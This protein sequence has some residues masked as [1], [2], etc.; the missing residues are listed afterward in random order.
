MLSREKGFVMREQIKESIRGLLA[1]G[2]GTQCILG[3]AWMLLQF[4]YM[5]NLQRTDDYIRAAQGFVM[6][7]YMG[8]LYPV[9]IAGANIL[10]N[11]SGVPFYCFLYLLQVSIA[12]AAGS[13]FVRL[14][15][16]GGGRIFSLPD[17]AV[18]LFLLTVPM[19]MQCH[20]AVLPLS[21]VCSAFLVEL[22]LCYGAFAGK[23]K[24]DSKFFLLLCGLWMVMGL[25]QPDYLWLA[26]LPV[27]CTGVFC[28]FRQG[29]WKRILAFVA[30][31]AILLCD[32][33]RVTASPGSYGRIQ[34]TMG[35]AMVSRM[36]WPNFSTTYFFWPEEVKEVMSEHQGEDISA[37]ADRVQTVFGPMMEEAFGKD[38][39]DRY[40]WQ[41]ALQCFQVRTKE[42]VGTIWADFM[43]YLCVPL[44]LKIQ[45][46]GGGRS[47]SG[48]NY[49]QMREHAPVLTRYYV[50][51]SLWMFRIG[52][53]IAVC[54]ALAA[55]AKRKKEKT[56]EK[57]K[58]KVKEKARGGGR[59]LPATA[60]WLLL[61]VVW[62]TMSGAGIM[63]Y[64]NVTPVTALW[65]AC[66][67]AAFVSLG[68]S[69][70]ETKQEKK[71][72]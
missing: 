41:M 36:V 20:L 39:A 72:R 23:R 9:L 64:L 65:Y 49:G 15:R 29:S 67:P 45:L 58:E 48:W 63:D 62:Y 40:Y 11:I 32:I 4:P 55:F 54:A 43:A 12:F 16:G 52:I 50:H 22:G 53:L 17:M 14:L 18:S 30:V 8:I 38:A 46:D 31:T 69:G 60:L 68:K 57:T 44:S 2:M 5:Q 37:Q 6:D 27:A 7:E 28:I 35:A 21:L 47:F 13:V 10:E 70:G 56:A 1:I 19:V 71:E 24:T 33:G 42:I 3:I 61:P 25:L 34:R 59:W 26:G 51:Y 66:L